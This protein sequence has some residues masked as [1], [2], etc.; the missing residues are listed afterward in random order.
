MRDV[1]IFGVD[2]LDVVIGCE[3]REM[4]EDLFVY[5]GF[6]VRSSLCGLSHQMSRSLFYHVLFLNYNVLN[7][8]LVA[9][10]VCCIP[11]L[12]RNVL[13]ELGSAH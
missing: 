7:V 6:A 9:V 4:Y 8:I 1:C 13:Y 11:F 12:L 2:G 10:G 3:T 5:L